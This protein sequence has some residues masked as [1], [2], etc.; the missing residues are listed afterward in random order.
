VPDRLWLPG[1]RVAS[2][3][4]AG[5]RLT[6]SLPGPAVGELVRLSQD[7]GCTPVAALLAAFQWLLCRVV[8]QRQFCVGTYA[9]GRARPG[10]E[11]VVGYFANILPIP[12]ELRRD[13][14]VLELIQRVQRALGGA[15]AHQDVPFAEIVSA[16]RPTRVQG[17]T[18]PLVQVVFGLDELPGEIDLG[19]LCCPR[20]AVPVRAAKFELTLQVRLGRG[21]QAPC[22]EWEYRSDMFEEQTV[23]LWGGLLARIVEQM[24]SRPGARLDQL[25][26]VTAGE[27]SA[28]LALGAGPSLRSPWTPVHVQIAQQAR[29]TPEAIA[30][31]SL[32]ELLTY[33]QLSALSAA[34]AASLRREG[35][36][37]GDPVGVCVERCAALPAVLL[38]VL[39]AGGAFVPLDPEAPAERLRKLV[40]GAGIGLTV[41]SDPR[42][43]SAKLGG[44]RVVGIPPTDDGLEEPVASPRAADP[45]YVM[46]T[47]GSA[48]EPKAVAVPHAALSCLF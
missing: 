38:G 18:A 39:Q 44:C 46:Y 36:C 48:G 31:A 30:V 6:T 33:R 42:Q 25:R 8:G 14:T 29:R 35:V 13:D 10:L 3:D 7:A 43:L 22:A 27:T 24:A 16:L 37:G 11:D 32:D 5:A 9:A 17:A 47:S 20:I 41:A 26:L 15:L 45:A 40:Q 23:A 4:H 2:G 34:V 21:A 1:A 28:L 19:G 12:A